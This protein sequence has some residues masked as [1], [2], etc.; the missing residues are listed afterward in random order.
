MGRIWIS[1]EVKSTVEVTH[2]IILENIASY[3]K[4][5]KG[6]ARK[7]GEKIHVQKSDCV[8]DAMQETNEKRRNEE[9]HCRQ[10]YSADGAGVH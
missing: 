6:S 7:E 8:L 10:R 1:E 2:I 4:M 3:G 5:E 9:Q